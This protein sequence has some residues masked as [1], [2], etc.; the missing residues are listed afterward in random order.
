MI[1]GQLVVGPL[2]LELRKQVA[3]LLNVS[4]LRFPGS[5][6][7]SFCREHL[8]SLKQENFYCCEKVL[9]TNVDGWNK[10]T[11]VHNI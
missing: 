10:I 2:K 11:F 6:P 4:H 5:Q 9:Q 8:K 1:P 3:D 7:V